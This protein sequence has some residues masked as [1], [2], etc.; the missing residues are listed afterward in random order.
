M[1]FGHWKDLACL[2]L[3]MHRHSSQNVSSFR[4]IVQ[5]LCQVCHHPLLLEDD[6]EDLENSTCA[7]LLKASGKLQ[8]LNHILDCVQIKGCRAMV[9]TQTTKVRVLM[10]DASQATVKLIK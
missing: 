5:D 8:I 2:T 3:E 9:L 10:C 6:P 1:N 7:S 4:R